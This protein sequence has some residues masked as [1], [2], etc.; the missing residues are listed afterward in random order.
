MAKL[1]ELLVNMEERLDYLNENLK[2]AGGSDISLES[3]IS[4]I[5]LAVVAIQ[6]ILISEIKAQDNG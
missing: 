4:E 3:R 2:N 5:T 1:K 6:Q